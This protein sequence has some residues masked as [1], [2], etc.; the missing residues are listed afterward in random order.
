[1]SQY[2]IFSVLAGDDGVEFLEGD[3]LDLAHPLAGDLEQL[4]DVAE[5]P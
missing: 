4:A 2:L 3:L 5:K 1:M